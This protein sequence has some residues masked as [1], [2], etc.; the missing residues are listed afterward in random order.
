ME[1][2]SSFG[3]EV[4]LGNDD[5]STFTVL[6]GVAFECVSDTRV[7]LLSFGTVSGSRLALLPFDGVSSTRLVLL[8]FRPVSETRLALL[9]LGGDSAAGLA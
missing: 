2:L 1:S 3:G 6:V 5:D 9:P 7:C 8:P 4:S